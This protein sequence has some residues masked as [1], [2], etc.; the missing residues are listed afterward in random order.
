MVTTGPGLS[1]RWGGKVAVVTGAAVGIGAAIASLGAVEGAEVWIM[2][3]D[4]LRGT[5][6]TRRIVDQ[7]A[8]ARFIQVDLTQEE[9]IVHGFAEVL[10][11]S[12]HVDILINNAGRDSACDPALMTVSEW[13][14]F[15]D[16]DL[17][18]SWLT[19]RAVLPSMI[20]RG[21][22]SI[23]NIASLH[24]TLTTEGAFPYA[25][26]KSGLLGLTRSLALEVGKFGV[27]V[28]ALSPGWTL[29]E[30]IVEHF[31][32]IGDS[33]AERIRDSHALRRI[34]EPREIAEVAVFLA[35]DAAS[36][37]TGSNW[38]ADGGLGA[39]YA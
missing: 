12:G 17:K 10:G 4:Q 37:V 25:A 35:S 22:G 13:D 6:T 8:R 23:V 18:A 1:P 3:A 24:G 9:A 34:A 29:S 11:E 2:D 16:L 15:M 5:T 26:A 36:W 21:H 14:S 38:A 19:S 27:R 33:E 20:K 7:G 32:S 39:R 28:N 31:E 30:R